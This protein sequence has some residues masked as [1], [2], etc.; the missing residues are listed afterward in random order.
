MVGAYCLCAEWDIHLATTTVTQV[1]SEGNSNIVK[2]KKNFQLRKV[3]SVKCP[4]YAK[5][6]IFKHP[7]SIWSVKLTQPQQSRPMFNKDFCSLA[8]KIC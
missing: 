7:K 6:R 3:V 4:L 8:P 1:S 2:T 5:Y